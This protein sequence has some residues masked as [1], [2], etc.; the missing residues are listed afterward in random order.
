MKVGS[1][2]LLA[3]GLVILLMVG[4]TEE[5]E[6]SVHPDGWA[7]PDSPNSHALKVASSGIESCKACH[8][9]EYLGGTSGVSCAECHSGGASGHPERFSFLNPDS[10]EYH[11]R[12]F[13]EN[14]WDFSR[15]QSCH[16]DDLD[17]E[18]GTGGIVGLSCSGCHTD[19]V[20]ACNTCHGI[21]DVTD[22]GISY[23]PK[24]IFNRTGS[25]RK[26]VGAHEAHMTSEMAVVSCD[27]CH[28]V[29]EDYLDEGH[30][31]SDNIA[32]ITFGTVATDGDSLESVWSRDSATCTSVYCHGSFAYGDV[33]GNFS[34]PVW[35]QPGSVPCG[36]CHG[37]PP[38][39]HPGDYSLEDC[40][41][42]HG[43]VVNSEGEIIDRSKHVN[44]ERNFQ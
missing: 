7:D 32:E 14:G 3:G 29:P 33:L 6:P 16:G 22:T 26:T 8:G 2:Q 23:P 19:G 41:D 11:G 20:K 5:G 35:T 17:E 1:W 42:C 31:G 4:C 9:M 12:I 43:A 36:S 28:I 18:N 25:T 40:S 24:D 34:T 44:G 10:S 15:C 39:G 21:W 13:W 30:L 38:E 27:E 37:I